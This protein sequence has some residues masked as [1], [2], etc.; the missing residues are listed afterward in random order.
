M[1]NNLEIINK[2]MRLLG[3]ILFL[4]NKFSGRKNYNKDLNFDNVSPESP[5]QDSQNAHLSKFLTFEM[6]G[7]VISKNVKKQG[8]II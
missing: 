1:K 5:E 6:T 2:N 8:K 3:P 7:K 4:Q